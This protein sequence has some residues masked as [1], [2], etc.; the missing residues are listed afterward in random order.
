[1]GI[2]ADYIDAMGAFLGVPIALVPTQTWAESL[3]KAKERQCD[4]LSLSIATPERKAYLDFT[5]P[6]LQIPLVLVAGEDKVFY[7][8]IATLTG[9]PIGITKGYA[10]GDILRVHYPHLQF[11]DTDSDAEGLKQVAQKK[12]FGFI[13]TLPTM[14]YQ[15]QKDYFGS[16]KIIGKLDEKIDLSIAVRNDEPLLRSLFEKAIDSIDA[17]QKQAILNKWISI[18]VEGRMDYTYVYTISAFIGLIIL[19]VLIRQYQLNQYN[20]K[21]EV[22]SNTD[23]LTGIYNRLKL[24]DILEQEKKLFDRYQAPLSIILFDLDLFKNVNDNYGHKR[25]D[26]VL[27]SI[28]KI[29]TE[30][31]RE[32][33]VF[34]R[35]GGEEFLLICRNTD[36]NGAKTL[37]EKMRESIATYLFPEVVSITASFGVAQFEKYDSIVKVFDKA[38]KALYEAKAQGRN[39][40]VAFY[41]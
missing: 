25:G 32:S 7:S 26:E 28:A 39:R 2:V 6:Y 22:L 20:A 18:N 8:D 3:L 41:M 37:A 15:I 10:Y 4:I 23:K 5:H 30:V 34:G 35:W 14:A 36:I 12:L 31:K 16:L 11:I 27:K 29:V 24:D 33:D 17:T 13:G 40:V 1:V 9:K 19:I 38:D 21:L